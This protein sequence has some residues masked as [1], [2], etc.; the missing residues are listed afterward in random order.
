MLVERYRARS[1]RWTREET[2]KIESMISRGL[3]PAQIAV[4]LPGRSIHA[5]KAR[6]R[7][8]KILGRDVP[9]T[10]DWT[11]P[12]MDRLERMLAQGLTL[13]KMVAA[14]PGRG[15]QAVRTKI[16]ALR[17]EALKKG[18]FKFLSNR[19]RWSPEQ[20]ERLHVLLGEGRPVDEV[21]R[22]LGHNQK[23]VRLK[24]NRLGIS[25]MRIRSAQ[26]CIA[27]MQKPDSLRHQQVW[28]KEEEQRLLALATLP[29]SYADI[30]AKL[31]RTAIAVEVRLRALSLGIVGAKRK[32]GQRRPCLGCKRLFNSE[33][34]HNRLCKNCR[35]TSASPFEP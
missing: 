27:T 26:K 7:G 31:N 15:L 29:L 25:I 10:P 33:G 8:M 11:R 18:E 4:E 34:P 28:T 35:Q 6:I 24:A 32:E 13:R 12:E 30:G 1:P 23:S 20:I 19:N 17:I 22:I 21:A 3:T 9:R 16:T 14:L 5:V 2:G